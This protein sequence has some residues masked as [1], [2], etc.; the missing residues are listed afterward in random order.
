MDENERAWLTGNTKLPLA[1]IAIGD[2]WTDPYNQLPKY[3]DWGYAVGLL[4]DKEA[5]TVAA[6]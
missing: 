2:G 6:F 5:D 1:G 3:A 4:S